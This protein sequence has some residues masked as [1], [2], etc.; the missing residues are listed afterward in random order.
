M[1]RNII[2][3]LILKREYSCFFNK[4]YLKINYNCI[5]FKLKYQ[6]KFYERQNI[7]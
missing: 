2:K 6:I 4:E 5:H 1:T 3:H 7:Y